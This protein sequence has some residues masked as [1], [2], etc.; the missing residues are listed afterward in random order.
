MVP[1][2]GMVRWVVLWVVL[3]CGLW[4]DQASAMSRATLQH[5]VETTAPGSVLSL[6]PGVHHGP[7]RIDHAITLTG[8]AGTIIDGGGQGSVITLTAPHVTIRRLTLRHSGTD[9]AAFDSAIL[10]MKTATEA[11]IEENTIR[12]ALFGIYLRGAGQAQVR[13]NRIEGYKKLRMADR[14]DGISMWNVQGAQIENNVMHGVR[15]GIFINVSNK[16]VIKNNIFKKLRFAIHYMYS[17]DNE[18]SGNRSEGNDIGFALM[19]SNRLKVFDNVSRGDRLNGLM[20]NYTNHSTLR[21]NRV[22]PGP[23][24]CIFVYNASFNEIH[25][26]HLEGCRIGI[27]FTAGSQDNRFHANAFVGNRTQVK[28]VGTTH[29]EWSMDGRGNYWS[30]NPAFDLNGD[31]IGDVAYRPNDLVD[32]VVWKY[33]LAKVLL[34]TPA[35][36]TLRFVQRQFPALLPGGVLDSHPLMRPPA[37]NP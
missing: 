15:D 5:A 32:H 21:N 34:T 11:R 28:Y 27:H 7:L 25:H 20:F 4:G 16:N 19:F 10:V 18:I 29:H 30:D 33:P 1:K 6:P 9:Q 35:I 14:G 23:E 3:W 22:M 36:Q 37:L 17:H 31:G 12:H 13:H 24:K 2:D 8:E 26:N